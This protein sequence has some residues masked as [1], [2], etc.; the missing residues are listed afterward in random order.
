MEAKVVRSYVDSEG[1]AYLALSYPEDGDWAIGGARV[2]IYA[3]RQTGED[4]YD[5][6]WVVD[7]FSSPREGLAVALGVFGAE[8]VRCPKESQ[9]MLERLSRRA[10]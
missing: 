1:Q 2:D 10:G 6:R 3:V 4:T 7:C 5:L 9:K 8:Y